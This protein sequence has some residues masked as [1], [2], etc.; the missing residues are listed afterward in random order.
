MNPILQ[1]SNSGV[2]KLSIFISLK[3]LL[4]LLILLFFY[5]CTINLYCNAQK[6]LF[7]HDLYIP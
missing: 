7:K 6:E 4:T 1:K 2:M 5:D 3:D